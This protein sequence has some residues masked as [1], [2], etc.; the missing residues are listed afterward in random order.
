MTSAPRPSRSATTSS[1][2]H[3]KRPCPPSSPSTPSP[4]ERPRPHHIDP[5]AAGLGM[6]A[7]WTV[8]LSVWRGGTLTKLSPTGIEPVGEDVRLIREGTR[9]LEYTRLLRLGARGDT[10]GAHRALGSGGAAL[11]LGGPARSTRLGGFPVRRLDATSANALSRST[12]SSS[13]DGAWK[14]VDSTEGVG[15]PWR[16]WNRPSPPERP[17]T[18]PGK[19]SAVG[20]EPSER[21]QPR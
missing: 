20:P 6:L 2:R 14:C 16:G 9:C 10:F 3:S 4:S 11:R 12:V 1:T 13:V 7:V 21:E 8:P 5:G 19:Q 17:P 18:S 15:C